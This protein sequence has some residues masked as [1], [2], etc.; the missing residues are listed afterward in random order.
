M[1]MDR[2]D[3]RILVLRLGSGADYLLRVTL[4][5]TGSYDTF[6]RRLTDAVALRAVSSN[7]VME[8]VHAKPSLPL[9]DVA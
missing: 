6:Y 1:T 8:V 3:K 5:D 7:F 9:L 2:I 4:A